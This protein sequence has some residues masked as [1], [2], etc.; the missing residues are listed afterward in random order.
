MNLTDTTGASV[1]SY[2]YD[3]WGALTSGSETIPN[4]GGW[5]NPYRFDGRQHLMSPLRRIGS[6]GVFARLTIL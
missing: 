3:A 2:S 4:A 6:G 5:V 1:A